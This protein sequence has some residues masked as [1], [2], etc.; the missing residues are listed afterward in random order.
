MV[1]PTF[2]Q[3]FP[4][5]SSGGGATGQD[6]MNKILECLAIIAS[7]Q[8]PDGSQNTP[9]VPQTANILAG[10]QTFSA[11]TAAT[12]VITIP[13]GRIWQG[14]I[15]I[16]TAV[17]IPAAGT[18]TGQALVV[19]SLSGAGS[20]PA[21]GNIGGNESWAG[22]NAAGGLSGTQGMNG[23][24]IPITIQA[25]SG[26]A[27]LVQATTTQVGANNRVDVTAAGVLIG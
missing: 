27:C 22:A 8:N 2:A 17:T 21:P 26:A 9:G 19:V 1:Q 15:C 25:G 12:T 14:T 6:V 24:A 7:G 10:Y 11:T 4:A 18:S 3:L 23:I 5:Y 16:S 20:T 13:Q